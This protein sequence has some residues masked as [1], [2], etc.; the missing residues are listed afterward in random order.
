MNMYHRGC[1]SIAVLDLNGT[2]AKNAAQELEAYSQIV[3][4]S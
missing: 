2:E 4:L 3:L 1:K